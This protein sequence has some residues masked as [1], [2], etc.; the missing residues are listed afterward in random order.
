MIVTGTGASPVALVTG[1]SHGIGRAI[2]IYLAEAGCR[3]ADN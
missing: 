3:L 2:A 1:G